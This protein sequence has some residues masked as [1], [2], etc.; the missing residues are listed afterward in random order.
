MGS[1]K[2]SLEEKNIFAENYDEI[3]RLDGIHLL[4]TV[5]Y[6]YFS[7]ENSTFLPFKSDQDP[8][9]HGSALVWLPGSGS[10]FALRKDI[11]IRIRIHIE[12]KADPQQ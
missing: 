1:P 8:D 12:I 2:E 5:L 6:A 7:C 3:R 10:G 4:P 11:W 9:P